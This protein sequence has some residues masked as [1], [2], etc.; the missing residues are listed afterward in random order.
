LVFVE[1]VKKRRRLQLAAASRDAE[2][3]RVSAGRDAI[4][5]TMNDEPYSDLRRKT[6]SEFEHLFEFVTRVDMKQGKRKR[7][8]VKCLASQMNQHA[9]IL[10]DRVQQHRIP[11]LR[12]RFPQNINRFAFKLAKMSP[13]VRHRSY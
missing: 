3:E 2:F 5:V 7:S 9:R 12:H 8:W 4:L 6:V 11:E 13:V 1:R 10:A